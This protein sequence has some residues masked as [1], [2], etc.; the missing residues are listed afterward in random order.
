MGGAL[1][2]DGA[3][4]V[5]TDAVLNLNNGPFSVLAWIKGGR[6]GEVIVSQIGGAHQL[7]ADLWI[8]AT[9]TDPIDEITLSPKAPRSEVV[10]TDGDW[11]RVGLVWDGTNRV[12]YVD[13]VAVAEVRRRSRS[14]KGIGTTRVRDNPNVRT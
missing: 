14:N 11:H 1:E 9:M 5:T 7:L 12:L 3:A 2:S 13:D 8:G 10:I 6:P 4:C